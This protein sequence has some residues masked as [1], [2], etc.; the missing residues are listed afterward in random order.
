MTDKNQGK[1][2]D[3]V[4][5]PD[6]GNTENAAEAEGLIEAEGPDV[7]TSLEDADLSFLEKNASDLATERLADLQR[8]QA[9]YANYRKRVER[10][11]EANRVL[12][13]A[14]VV[15]SL[16][17]VLDDLDRAEAHGDLEDG[18]FVIIAQ[19]LRS[20]L[21]RTGLERVGEKGAE[22]DPSVYEAIAQVPSPDVT[23]MTVLDVHKV[24]Y[25][26]GDRLLRAAQVAVA[27]PQD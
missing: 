6:V 2:S 5:E 14:D 1:N 3:E 13:V 22:F 9:E 10:D 27:V 11:R 7:E 20:T 16:L 19:K 8:L 12:A 25:R 23:V 18:P 15:S 17:P 21:E 26:L 24:G 4:P